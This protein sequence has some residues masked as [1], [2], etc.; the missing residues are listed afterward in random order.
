MKKRIMCCC[1][2]LILLRGLFAFMC[3]GAMAVSADELAQGKTLQPGDEIS[4]PENGAELTYAYSAGSVGE[5]KENISGTVVP[6]KAHKLLTAKKA[7]LTVDDGWQFSGWYCVLSGGHIAISAQYSAQPTVSLSDM[8]AAYGLQLSAQRMSAGGEVT[9]SVPDKYAAYVLELTVNG[10]AIGYSNGQGKFRMPETDAVVDVTVDENRGYVA[11]D[12]AGGAFAG[13]ESTVGEYVQIDNGF[14]LV[15]APD[16]LEREGYIFDGWEG[17]DAEYMDGEHLRVLLQPFQAVTLRAK[18]VPDPQTAVTLSF[19][20]QGG[21]VDTNNMVTAP[22]EKVALPAA[23][24]DSYSFL[25]WNNRPDGSGEMYA[26]GDKF[27]P[28]ED[29]TLYACWRAATCTVTV[30]VKHMG[31]TVADITAIQLK[32]AYGRVIV[33]EDN[34]T[35]VYAFSNVP[36]GEYTLHISDRSR[37]GSCGGV[38]VKNGRVV[39]ATLELEMW[40]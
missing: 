31:R 2:A 30:S 38:S 27:A 35:G 18:W 33:G 15:S 34:G 23:Y 25:G 11:F 17:F 14:A 29:M 26:P 8:A 21:V 12:A 9:V 39:A 20:A 32:D 4:V 1:A 40:N 13:G 22:G 24:R 6:G 16:D 5:L 3:V 28:D 10:S 37:S 7:G 36:D 19:D